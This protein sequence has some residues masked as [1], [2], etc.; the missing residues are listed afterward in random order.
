VRFPVLKALDEFR[1]TDMPIL[2]RQ[3]ILDEVGFAPFSKPGA[4]TPT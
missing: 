4:M 2:N 3:A 1:F